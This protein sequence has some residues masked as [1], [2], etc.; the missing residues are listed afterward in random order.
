M[1]TDLYEKVKN[2]QKFHQLVA[3]RSKLAWV[4]SLIIFV[5]YFSFILLIAFAPDIL[6]K[7]INS[8]SFITMGIPVGVFIIVMSFVLTGIYVRK[9]NKEYDRINQEIIEDAQ[10]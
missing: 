1:S 2:N 8:G 7:P 5:V 6:G 3:R 10:K 4:L 9:A